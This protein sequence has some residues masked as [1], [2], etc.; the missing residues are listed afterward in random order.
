MLA[1]LLIIGSAFAD[2]VLVP[3][4][5]PVQLD[6]IT[7]AE[8]ADTILTEKLSEL[9]LPVVPAK[10]IDAEYPQ[11]A[12]S[13]FDIEDCP[14]QLLSR[15]RAKM[16]LVG[17]VESTGEGV[18]LTLRIYGGQDLSPLDVKSK[19]IPLE[20][21]AA[22]LNSFAQDASVIHQLMP[23]EQPEEVASQA[24]QSEPNIVII[25]K[26]IERPQVRE[27]LPPNRA[28]LSLPKKYEQMY[29]ESDL[30]PA[31]FLRAHRVRVDNVSVE[32]HAGLGIGDVS[33][34]YDSR[35]GFRQDAETV[36]DVY[37]YDTFMLDN[38][39]MF[40]GSIYYAPFWWMDFG[41]YGGVIIGKSKGSLGWE[42][43][44][45]EGQ[46]L[47]K[48]S[49][50]QTCQGS[51]CPNFQ[52]HIEPRVR[53]FLSPAGSVKPYLLG[54]A[55][56]RIYAPLLVNDWPT[57]RFA[58]RPNGTHYGVTTGF[59]MAFDSTSPVGVF[60]EIPWSYI[61]NHVPH[62]KTQNLLLDVPERPEYTNQLFGIKMG[63]SLRFR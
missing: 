5:T 60:F 27:Q 57:V 50:P 43:Q 56:F 20:E 53:F 42:Q 13:C 19:N 40:G 30:S 39:P 51:P 63:M 37:E 2:D 24:A 21:L 34:S 32:M 61:F 41:V 35:V 14:M 46:M 8:Q 11:V 62:S 1:L 16:L 48:E 29:Y 59:G 23:E 54:G 44:S 52:G 10:V 45:F 36:F 3:H 58:D 17:S 25:E 28:I 22:T 47:E 7:I 49:V 4:F 9:G 55:L 31:D 18:I 12:S 26:T 33:R 15:P 6:D 38:G